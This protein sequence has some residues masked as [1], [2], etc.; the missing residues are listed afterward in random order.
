MFL[1][2]GVILWDDLDFRIMP[3]TREDFRR[4]ASFVQ[5][6]ALGEL[7]A[8]G[9]PLKALSH[10]DINTWLLSSA[11]GDRCALY[12]HNFESHAA[13]VEDAYVPVPIRGSGQYKIT[14]VEPRTGALVAEGKLMCQGGLVV[15]NVPDFSGDIAGVMV[16]ER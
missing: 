1:G 10:K 14:W 6:H 12:V 9:A 8:L 5:A 3:E 2:C 11:A 7:Q 16:R 4:L 13:K 15:V